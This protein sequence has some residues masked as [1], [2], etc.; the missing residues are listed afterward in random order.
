MSTSISWPELKPARIAAYQALRTEL[1]KPT[2]LT[3]DSRHTWHDL[4][5]GPVKAGERIDPLC[6][7]ACRDAKVTLDTINY[8]EF[9]IA[10]CKGCKHYTQCF[11]RKSPFNLLAKA[12]L[13]ADLTALRVALD[14]YLIALGVL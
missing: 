1:A 6:D 12:G 4:L 10:P 3:A 7:L 11:D 13:T 14:A 9:P 2:V 8:A 5:L